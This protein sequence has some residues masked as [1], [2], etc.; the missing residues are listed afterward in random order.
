MSQFIDEDPALLVLT[1]TSDFQ[2][3]GLNKNLRKSNEHDNHVPDYSSPG[4]HFNYH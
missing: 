1:S 4:N 3:L 2:S